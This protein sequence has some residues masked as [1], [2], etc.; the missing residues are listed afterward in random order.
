MA[1]EL[2]YFGEIE[3]DKQD[4]SILSFLE[5]TDKLY[6]GTFVLFRGHIYLPF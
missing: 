3:Q 5:H 2:N 4:H 1:L 6:W